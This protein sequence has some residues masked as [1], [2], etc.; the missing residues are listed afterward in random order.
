VEAVGKNL[1]FLHVADQELNGD[2]TIKFLD[3]GYVTSKEYKS[4][5]V[6]TK[7][8]C[9]KTG[10]ADATC[11]DSGISKGSRIYHVTI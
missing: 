2:K 1:M 5:S 6:F 8:E 10:V 4:N 9:Y 11:I 7:K 3:K